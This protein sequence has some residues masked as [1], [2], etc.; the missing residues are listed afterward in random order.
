MR[1]AIIETIKKGYNIKISSIE[2]IRES[3]DNKV[4]LIKGEHKNY[5]ARVSKRDI[6]QDVF[7]EITWL[8]YLS[9][10]NIPVVEIIKTTNNEFFSVYHKSV[11]VLFKFAEGQPVEITP[12]KKPDLRKVRSA[13]RELAKI[14]NVS[15]NASIKIPRKRNI[16]T[17]INR[18]LK[19]KDKF[20]K[21]SEGGNKFIEELVFYKKWVKKNGNNKFL[22][23]NDYRPGNIF[24][25]E[26][27]M[28][29]ILDFDWSCK[30]PAIKDVAHSLCEWSFPDGAKEHWQ[31]V[32]D[33][34][35]KSYNKQTKRKIKI[36]KDLFRWICFSCLSDVATYLT[37]LANENIF[38]KIKSSYMYQKFLYFERFIK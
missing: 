11:I 2:L 12:N 28:S 30:G 32:F 19:I 17:E 20:I 36:N 37:N 1:K 26:N 35:L 10:K 3:S 13:A 9:R 21:L 18:A 7:F 6:R 38:K 15:Y 16:L 4:Y 5:I 23:H 14:H 34:F 22:V 31:D 8:D 25:N 29:A 27:K 33:T 24:F